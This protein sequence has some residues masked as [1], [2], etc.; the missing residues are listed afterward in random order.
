MSFSS[1]PPDSAEALFF[2]FSRT[3]GPPASRSF[4]RPGRRSRTFVPARRPRLVSLLPV[5][6]YVTSRMV[7]YRC[8]QRGAIVLLSACLLWPVGRTPAWA[9]ASPPPPEQRVVACAACHGAQGEG[10]QI[11]EYYPRIA[12][13]PAGYLF[14]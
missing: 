8:M 2:S 14:N 5:L 9:A 4:I 13:K 1:S 3:G 6:Q 7:Q 11:N 10:Q 12:A